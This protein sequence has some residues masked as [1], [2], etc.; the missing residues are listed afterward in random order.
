M[1]HTLHTIEGYYAGRR[2]GNLHDPDPA[3]LTGCNANATLYQY[4]YLHFADNLCYWDRE[5]IELRNLVQGEDERMPS[6]VL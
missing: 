4:V 6:C 1:L 3:Q 5:L 2:H